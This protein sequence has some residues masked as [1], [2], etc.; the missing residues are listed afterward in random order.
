MTNKKHVLF[1]S[2]EELKALA[3]LARVAIKMGGET[4]YVQKLIENG[5][6]SGTGKLME[7]IKE[8]NGDR[9]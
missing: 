8:I 5:G 4:P 6:E 2:E 9:K 7:K 1:F 3:N